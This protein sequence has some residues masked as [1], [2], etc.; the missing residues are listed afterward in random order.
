MVLIF[1]ILLKW[2]IKRHC[3]TIT[4]ENRSVNILFSLM[5][6][7]DVN[8]SCHITVWWPVMRCSIPVFSCPAAVPATCVPRSNS[9]AWK[10]RRASQW[11]FRITLSKKLAELLPAAVEFLAATQQWGPRVNI[12]QLSITTLRTNAC[13]LRFETQSNLGRL[14]LINCPIW[15]LIHDRYILFML[16][17]RCRA[18][19]SLFKVYRFKLKPEE[20]LKLI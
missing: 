16:W 12:H 10:S 13:L 5:K 11:S 6:K 8:L 17:Q 18:D 14:S 19:D 20:E 4:F 2:G 9:T 7:C 3:K 15:A 1:Y